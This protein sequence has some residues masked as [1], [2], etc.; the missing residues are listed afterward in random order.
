[1]TPDSSFAALVD[2]WIE[3]MEI[4][5]RLSHTTRLLY[6]RNI[7]KLVL[8]LFE[9]LTLREIGVARCDYF[10]K[11][12][13]KDSYNKARQARVAMRLALGLAVRHEL[14]PRNPMDHVSR[15]R[16][17]SREVNTFTPAEVRYIRTAIRTWEEREVTAG[18]RPDGQLGQIVEVM[19][20][21]S[22]RIGEVLAIRLC[23]LDLKSAIPTVRICGTIV[24]RACEPTHRQDHPKTAQSVRRIA[25][26]KFAVDAIRAR[27]R[28][29]IV[30]GKDTL[31][32]STRRG[33]PHTTNNI[34]RRLRDVTAKA[35]IDAVTPHRFRCAVATAINDAAGIDLAATLLGH[36]D[37]RITQIH[38]VPRDEIV[39][40]STTEHLEAA[41]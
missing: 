37:S 30:R 41:G 7:R 11:Q 18:P 6:E 3:D 19:L 26:P 25:L 39:D 20:G 36:T 5:D 13:A 29:V 40:A 24:S 4:E 1:M 15:L 38:Y 23:D 12:L 27:L 2:Y 33:T 31:L 16:R 21:T 28:N 17:P 35:G 34:R 32:F 10:I 9:N 14:I 22:A 8:P